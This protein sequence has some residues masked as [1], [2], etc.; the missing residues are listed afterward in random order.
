MTECGGQRA[1][2]AVHRM[3]LLAALEAESEHEE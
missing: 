3:E 1:D 2:H